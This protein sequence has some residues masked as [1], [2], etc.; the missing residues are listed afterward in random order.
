MQKFKEN[1]EDSHNSKTSP[2]FHFY[3]ESPNGIWWS[4][5]WHKY[6]LPDFL[7]SQEGELLMHRDQYLIG[8]AYDNYKGS[9]A[10]MKALF[11]LPSSINGA[12]I[13]YRKKNDSKSN[14]E[15]WH[16]LDLGAGNIELQYQY[17][18][19]YQSGNWHGF[20]L[21]LLYLSLLLAMVIGFK[22]ALASAAKGKQKQGL[23]TIIAL[24][25]LLTLVPQFLPISKSLFPLLMLLGIL[26]FTEKYI[27]Y[28]SF[29][30]MPDKSKIFGFL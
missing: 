20:P 7:L 28:K 10:S 15:D 17:F 2:Y 4:E 14:P 9:N 1:S 26:L 23:T 11:P 5:D 21:F 24:G 8:Y 16:S 12:K 13:H 29:A 30:Q 3:T 6:N 19:D 18:W 25:V 27:P 22:E